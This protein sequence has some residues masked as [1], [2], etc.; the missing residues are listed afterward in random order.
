MCYSE[1]GNILLLSDKIDSGTSTLLKK[2]LKISIL[3]EGKDSFNVAVAHSALGK[4]YEMTG[5]FVTASQHF[6]EA[7]R[8]LQQETLG[9]GDDHPE[10]LEAKRDVERIVQM[11]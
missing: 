11:T 6:A 9:F 7:L 2:S 10:T 4:F 3:F 1:L 8:I 5:M